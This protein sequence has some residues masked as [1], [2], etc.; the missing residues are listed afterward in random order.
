MCG[1]AGAWGGDP[2]RVE[3]MI[4]AMGSRG[5]DRAAVESIDEVHLG[6]ARLAIRGGPR[7]DQPLRAGRGTLVFNGEIYNSGEL[8]KD[9]ARHGIEVTGESD[10]EIVAW[11]LNVYGIRAVDRLN[12]MFALAWYDGRTLQLARDPAGI[13]PLYYGN[14]AFSSTIAP[15]LDGQR[16][17]DAT[18]VGRWLTFHVAY[19]EET[20]FDGVRRVPAGG[21][22]ELPEGRVLRSQALGLGF[23]TPNPA[24]TE[25]RLS[26]VLQRSVRDASPADGRYGVALSGGIDST[27]VAALSVG[28][29]VAYHG[30]VAHEGCDE[31]EYARA[32]AREIGI[33]LV[34]VPITADACWRVLPHV[35]RALEEP[36]AGPGS[37][38]QYLV[39][40]RAAEDVRVL[41]SG[42]GGDEL[43]GGYARAVALV[44]ESPPPGWE[45]YAPLF[46]RAPGESNGVRAFELLQRREGTLFTHDFLDAHPAPR[47]AFVEA[48]EDGGLGPLASAARAEMHIV[49]PGLLQVEDRVGMAHSLENRVPLLDRRLL[50]VATRLSESARVGGDGTAKALLR[51]AAARFLPRLVRERRDKMG[52]PLPLG[53]WFGGPWREPA[54]EILLDRRTRERGLIDTA[55][56]ENALTGHARYDRGLY[57]ALLFA[58]WCETFLDES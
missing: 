56:V 20:F 28:D 4:S 57:S 6:C 22:V 43:F 39:A 14:H 32:A 38:A 33:P 26:K 36:V 45:N 3:R 5:P 29:R 54:R 30:H 58:L 17:L 12:G 23:G 34:E 53:D 48:F 19:G 37:M 52:F 7:G 55:A 13:K 2:G 46:A 11:L 16:T 25:D 51:G 40:E 24:L 31:S 42:C 8:V 15:L 1:I 44:H 21:I 18:A 49:L 35:V 9:L 47:A 27:L 10:T 50:K 41:L